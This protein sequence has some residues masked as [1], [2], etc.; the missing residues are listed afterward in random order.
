[1]RQYSFHRDRNDAHKTAL[2][3]AA[4][5]TAPAG[6]PAHTRRAAK[7]KRGPSEIPRKDRLQ[8]DV[9]LVF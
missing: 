1:M 4:A 7:V 6:V 5:P 8:N 9:V 2:C 3:V